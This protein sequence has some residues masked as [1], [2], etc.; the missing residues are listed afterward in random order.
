MN[1]H[2][3]LKVGFPHFWMLFAVLIFIFLVACST[4]VE[5][6][7][8]AAPIEIPSKTPTF[9]IPSSI[10]TARE[11]EAETDCNLADGLGHIL[12]LQQ[13][14]TDG[15]YTSSNFDL[16]VMN[17]NG[18]FPRLVMKSVSGAPAW[19]TDGTLIAIGCENNGFICILDARATLENCSDFETQIGSCQPVILNEYPL[20][21]DIS[22]KN[23]MYNI[24][25]TSESSRLAIEGENLE[26][27]T[28]ILY[29][30]T[31]ADDE[32][33]EN[34]IERE[35]SFGADWS[36]TKD[37][38]VI[39]GNLII[40]SD[41]SNELKLVSGKDP[42]WSPDGEQMIF[43]KGS[44]DENKEAYGIALLD[45]KTNTWEWLY[46]PANRDRY[47]WPP[48][49]LVMGGSSG[50]SQVLS[51]SP[52]GN[53]IAF[54][55]LYRHGYDSQIF[56]LDISTGEIVVLTAG[57]SPKDGSPYYYSPAWGP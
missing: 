29:L 16:Y 1:E 9:R 49:N 30:L 46:E 21:L 34:L 31:L 14:T 18:C 37:Q 35:W 48:Q 20:P 24:S 5:Q 36:P 43:L 7:T 50:Y 53:F 12:F 56:R 57:L 44:N 10:P 17:G 13:H 26:T 51:W 8:E 2:P 32:R 11:F 23:M 19:S 28:Y 25:F 22:G 3:P 54:V 52:D 41:G 33:W 47:Y 39:S 45:V 27:N 42:E 6:A 40:N 55:S 15:M 38:F 4:T